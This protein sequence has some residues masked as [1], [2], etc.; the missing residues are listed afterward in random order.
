MLIEM[1]LREIQ[2]V[3]DPTRHQVVVL[4]E[5]GGQRAFPIYI[6]LFEASAMD[7]AVHGQKAPRPM[8]HDLIYNVLDGVG[9]RL[10][11]VRVD[12]LR[13]ETF[14]GKL[15]LEKE[16]GEA[17]LIDS[18]PSDALILAAKNRLPVFVEEAVLDE[19]CR[20]HPDQD[21]EP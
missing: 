1:E 18:R 14:F 20:H 7:L 13:S 12:E 11:E 17:V 21:A 3:D 6:G 16:D 9:A 2:I 5:K 4:A 10:V 15:V 19:V 8:T